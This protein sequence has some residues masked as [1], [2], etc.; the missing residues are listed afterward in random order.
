MN[1]G[2]LRGNADGDQ[3]ALAL[4]E[5]VKLIVLGYHPSV[6]RADANRVEPLE[7][8]PNGFLTPEVRGENLIPVVL[9]G[10]DRDIVREVRVSDQRVVCLSVCSRFL[11]LIHPAL[12]HLA[13]NT[14]LWPVL[15]ESICHLP[16]NEEPY[17]CL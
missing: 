12:S 3:N 17:L 5:E 4:D 2:Y 6:H 15:S 7:G 1:R 11:S 8:F 9:L 13:W 16:V 10:D 14:V